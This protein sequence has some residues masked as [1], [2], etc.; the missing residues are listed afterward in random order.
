[1]GEG[2]SHDD[3]EATPAA[4]AGRGCAEAMLNAG[5]DLAEVLQSLKVSD[6]TY[7]RW[8][9]QYGGMKAPGAKRLK[10][11][12]VPP[13]HSPPGSSHH[14]TARRKF[15]AADERPLRSCRPFAAA[16]RP[17]ECVQL[18]ARRRLGSSNS[19]NE[20][21]RD[22]VQSLEFLPYRGGN[23]AAVLFKKRDHRMI[24]ERARRVSRTYRAEIL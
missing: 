5:K 12:K 23:L 18:A 21:S 2:N 15:G 20:V 22:Q 4:Q 17:D 3:E 13:R 14:Q 24:Q 7:Y 1:M 19:G 10:E 6:R 16:N 8:R 9:N 11:L